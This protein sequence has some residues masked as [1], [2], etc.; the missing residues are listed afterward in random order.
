M[1]FWVRTH[2]FAIVSDRRQNGAQR[3][4]AHGNVQEMSGE[5]E[6]VVMSENRHQQIPNQV[7]ESLRRRSRAISLSL[8]TTLLNLTSSTYIV[9]KNNTKL[10]DLVLHVDRCYPTKRGICLGCGVIY[11]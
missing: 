10:P 5:E 8:F 6:V 1:L 3:F 9:R 7:E 2:L 11:T 4:D